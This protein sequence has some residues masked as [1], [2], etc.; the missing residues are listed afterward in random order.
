MTITYAIMRGSGLISVKHQE[1]IKASSLDEDIL[2]LSMKFSKMKCRVFFISERYL[3]PPK[4][5]ALLSSS[6]FYK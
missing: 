3:M 6:A 2:I 4:R 5:D 1:I